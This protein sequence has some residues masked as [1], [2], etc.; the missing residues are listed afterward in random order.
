MRGLAR[1]W[2]L[3][4]RHAEMAWTRPADRTII[5]RAP[6]REPFLGAIVAKQGI[7][8]AGQLVPVG[9]QGDIV[10]LASRS[11]ELFK[12]LRPKDTTGRADGHYIEHSS[13]ILRGLRP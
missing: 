9:F 3:A 11:W 13:L 2:S 1:I 12:G 5:G 8:E 10:E 6:Q 4:A 7:E